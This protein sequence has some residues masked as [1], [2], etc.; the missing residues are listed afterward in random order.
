LKPSEVLADFLKAYEAKDI[1]AIAP[2]L[3]DDVRL[4]DWH[5]EAHGK[6]AV[7][8]E[9]RKNF[10]DAQHLQNEI[11]QLYEGAGCAAA[12]VRIVVNKSVELEVVDTIAVNPDG[13]V[14]SIRAYKG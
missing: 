8:A 3:T 12:Q 14:S 4:Q 9:T 5:L 1:D 13:K 10:Q 6:A 11:R 2:M 7:L